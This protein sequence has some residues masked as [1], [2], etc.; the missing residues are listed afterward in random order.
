VGVVSLSAPVPSAPVTYG[1]PLTL[2]GLVRGV[3]GTVTLEQRPSGGTWQPVGP[4]SAGALK[5]TQRPTVTT[6]YRLATPTAAGAF[7][8]VRVAPSVTL[9]SFTPT[10]VAGSEQPVLLGAAVQVQQQNPDQTWTTV[11]SGLVASDGTFSVA[12]SLTEGA[13]YRVTVGP[14]AGYVAAVTAPQIV[15]R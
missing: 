1:S 2:F 14:A 8:R 10:E 12:V 11:A 15:M 3:D 6:D 7:V 4:V 13:T 9:T 5:L